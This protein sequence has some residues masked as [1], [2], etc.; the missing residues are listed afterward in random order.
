MCRASLP[1]PASARVN[2]GTSLL[3]FHNIPLI[4]QVNPIQCGKGLQKGKNTRRRESL[5]HFGGWL[6]QLETDLSIFALLLK[7]VYKAGP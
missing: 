1:P 2:K 5:G 4:T 6:P 3:H 7:Q